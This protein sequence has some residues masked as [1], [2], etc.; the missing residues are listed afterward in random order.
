MLFQWVFPTGPSPA[1]R[2]LPT[3]NQPR[4]PVL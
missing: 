2:Q 4:A 3:A 1:N